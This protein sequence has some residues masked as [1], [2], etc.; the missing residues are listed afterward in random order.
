M[1]GYEPGI[2]D[3]RPKNRIIELPQSYT[4]VF[5]NRLRMGERV[6]T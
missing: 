5:T 1:I 4:K 6:L 3:G 2:V